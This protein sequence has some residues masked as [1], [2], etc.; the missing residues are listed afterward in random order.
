V[1]GR[2]E[3]YA[4]LDYTQKDSGLQRN[5]FNF[6]EHKFSFFICGFSFIQRGFDVFYFQYILVVKLQ[7]KILV[8]KYVFSLYFQKRFSAVG[9]F[10]LF[11][12]CYY[13]T[14][15]LIIHSSSC[16]IS[17]FSKHECGLRPYVTSLPEIFCSFLYRISV[18]RK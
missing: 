15:P 16:A 2:S 17:V 4:L 6:V 5:A 3:H 8:S 18:S 7:W 12:G 11:N 9:T 10:I 1:Y 13:V 14:Y